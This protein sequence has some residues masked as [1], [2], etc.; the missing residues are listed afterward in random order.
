MSVML[1]SAEHQQSILTLVD[2]YL[3]T[4]ALIRAEFFYTCKRRI[5]PTSS[6][7]ART[8]T[9]AA[10]VDGDRLRSFDEIFEKQLRRRE[11]PD[12]A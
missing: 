8:A 10:D 11:S 6:T 7:I 5:T 2:G 3:Q 4:D 9:T 1:L 12:K